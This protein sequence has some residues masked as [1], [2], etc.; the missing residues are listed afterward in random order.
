MLPAAELATPLFSMWATVPHVC[1][2]H[3]HAIVVYVPG[4]N[5]E[6]QLQRASG[7]VRGSTVTED[8]RKAGS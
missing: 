6:V 1:T 8:S 4:N 7:S 2:P 3:A 5:A